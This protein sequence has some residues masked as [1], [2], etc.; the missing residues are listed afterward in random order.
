MNLQHHFLILEQ[1]KRGVGF[2]AYSIIEPGIFKLHKLYLLPELQGKGAGKMLLYKVI[3]NI[4]RQNAETLVLTV[5]RNN[6]NAKYF[7]E[8]LGFTVSREE[9]MDI[10]RGYFMDDYVMRLAL[11]S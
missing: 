2:A 7:Y 5:N 4:R 10:G 11:K 8:K 9:K 6:A 1:E 3:E